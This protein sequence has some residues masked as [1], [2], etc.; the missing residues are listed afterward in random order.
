MKTKRTSKGITLIALVITIIVLLILAGVSIAMLTG[1]NGIITQANKAKVQQIHG[2]VKEG[3]W[4]AYN[5]YQIEIKTEQL[6]ENETTK[7]ASTEIVRIQGQEE[8]SLAEPQTSFIEYLISKGYAKEEIINEETIIII[9]VENLVGER[10]ALGNGTGRND[11]YVLENN[12]LYY[13]DKNENSL[14]LGYIEDLGNEDTENIEDLF[15][16]DDEGA[17]SVKN[18]EDYYTWFNSDASD[19]PIENLV[20]PSEIDGKTVTKI[21]SDFVKTFER[22]KKRSYTRYRNRNWNICF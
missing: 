9:N 17:I 18:Y 11:V 22:N 5:E 3:V 2:Q 10:L 8:K 16:V 12:H 20:I 14:D 19:F 21:S 13:Y 15:E 6:S 1:E 7:I 4:L